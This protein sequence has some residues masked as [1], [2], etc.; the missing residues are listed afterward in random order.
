M[1]RKNAVRLLIALAGLAVL[2]LGAAQGD[3]GET[4]QKAVR[5]CLECVGIG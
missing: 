5:L 2:A 1:T 4:M 3:V